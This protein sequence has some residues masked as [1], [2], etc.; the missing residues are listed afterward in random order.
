MRKRLV[1]IS[2]VTLAGVLVLL[3][4]IFWGKAFAPDT[5]MTAKQGKMDVAL[6]DIDR[7]PVIRLDGEWEFYWNKLLTTEDFQ[8]E[9][10]V[11]SASYRKVPSL[12]SEK[13][14]EG[15]KFPAFG[16]AT[17]RLVLEQVPFRG[18]LV[19]KKV[20]IRFSS[21]I[22]VNGRELITDGIPAQQTANYRSGNT[23]RLGF[24]ENN[25]DKIEIIVQVANYEYLN[26]GIPAS[27]ELGRED[28]MLEQHQRKQLAALLIFAALCMIA[29]FHLI[30]F[31]I[32]RDMVLRNPVFLLFS[33]FCFLF[34]WGNGLSDQRSLLLLLPD[35]PFT[36]AFKLKDLC[37]SA[38]FIVVLWIF[39]KFRGGL[40]PLRI[41]RL[42]SLLYGIYLA[43]IM[44]LPIHVY[45]KIHAAVMVCNTVVLLALL[46][47]AVRYYLRNAEGLLLFAALLSINL[48][49][50]DAILFS[51]GIKENSGFV[52]VFIL[53]FTVVMIAYL[54][55]EYRG[56]VERLRCSMKQ[57]QDAEMAFLR[58]QIK[59]HFLYNTLSVI[60]VQTTQEPQKARNLLYD[61]TDYLRGS[62]H[63]ETHEGMVP[64]SEELHTVKAY[65]SIEQARFGDLLQVEYDIGEGVDTMV[66]L[67]SLQPIV[68]NSVRHGIFKRAEGGWLLLQIRR[69]NDYVVIRVEDNGVGIPKEQL[70]GIRRGDNPG[71][72]VGLKNIRGRLGSYLGARL[73]IESTEGIGTVVTLLIPYR[74]V[75]HES[76]FSG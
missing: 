49:S 21:R 20:N 5:R 16:C 72:G 36:L 66:P 12:W 65:L 25:S 42:V 44:V 27:L 18:K 39:Y 22:Y 68:E 30:F 53:L 8:T 26:S 29:L 54:G 19:L 43:M 33:L 58:A 32:T 52:Q 2:A 17:Y 9:K 70:S 38:D 74:E 28:T 60:A 6:W 23:P 40:L 67:L 45:Y 31:I 14:A 64:L 24:F 3:L 35:I 62:F 7:D 48:Y 57:A 76:D 10:T 69:E 41:A 56:T 51:L 15:T 63:F 11:Q 50:L 4:S 37:L 73:D 13:Q 55:L 75:L 71:A 34:A 1:M 59:P 47:R 61:L 46:S